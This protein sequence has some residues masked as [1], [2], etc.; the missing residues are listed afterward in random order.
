MNILIQNAIVGIQPH[1]FFSIFDPLL[2]TL[3]LNTCF[4]Y[5]LRFYNKTRAH[6]F[7]KLSLI[8]FLAKFVPADF[9]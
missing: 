3:F 9:D 2:L 8:S 4:C 7:G 6:M 1:S 5:L